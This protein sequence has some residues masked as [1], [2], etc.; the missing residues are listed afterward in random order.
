LGTPGEAAAANARAKLV[1]RP[2]NF[3]FG[4][5]REGGGVSIDAFAI[6]RDA[7][8]PDIAYRFVDFLLRAENMDTDARLAG[9]VSAEDGRDVETLKK[10]TPLGAWGDAFAAAVDTEWTHLRVAK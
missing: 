1:G 2:G 4:Y 8:N 10:L 3:V 6:P 9:V 5:A 7:P